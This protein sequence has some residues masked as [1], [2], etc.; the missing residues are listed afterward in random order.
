MKRVSERTAELVQQLFTVSGWLPWQR[1]GTHEKVRTIER[2]A[3]SDE[4]GV[5]L[6][7]LSQLFDRA[8]EVANA[9]A[10]AIARLVA[11]CSPEDL[12][13]LD[14]QLRWQSEW[15]VG[16]HWPCLRPKEIANLPKPKQ[17]QAAVFGL[18][19]F[20][21]NGHVREKAVRLLDSVLDGS[22]LPFLLIRMNDWVG[23]VQQ[24]AQRAVER[25]LESEP[26][27]LFARNLYYVFRLL[28][29]QR[30][31][32]SHFVHAVVKKLTQVEH[33]VVLLESINSGDLFV[34]RAV[35]RLAVKTP[36]EHVARLVTAGFRSEDPIL[37]L[38][39]VREAPSVCENA[40]L[41]ALLRLSEDDVFMPVRRETLW[42]RIE[43]FPHA[44]EQVLNTALL[45]R[46]PAVREEARFHLR[47]RGMADCSDFYRTAIQESDHIETA[48]AG[49]GET[50]TKAD[51][52]LAVPL[53]KADRARLRRAAVRTIGRL[54]PEQHVE[55]LIERLTD[56]SPRVALEAARALKDCTQFADA[57]ELWA[58]FRSD[59]R[60][61]V[62][63]AVL[64]LLDQLDTWR[65]LPYLIRAASNLNERVAA[66]AMVSI[67]G[68][69]NRVFTHPSA[70][71]KQKIQKAIDEKAGALKPSF[72]TELQKW[73]DTMAK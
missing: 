41:A 1:T 30:S 54:A 57:D 68:M 73:V 11:T 26:F 9:A 34:R 56:D 4:S 21:G 53:L 60:G 16:Q 71:D 66:R 47:K 13:E 40:E 48:I 36:G 69:Y 19:S 67:S 24:V 8:P 55:C 17:S 43:R 50:G 35:F 12:Y 3:A 39:A 45:D 31:D 49:L 72:R 38:W 7:L 37:R 5:I 28:E 46:S 51:A 62:N 2:I 6:P 14:G 59:S 20:H 65:K 18:A 10:D 23:P 15:D 42:A 44:A 70:E 52:P 27:N 33:E 61:H 58:I 25:R 63:L 22:E 32:H 29:Q 64:H